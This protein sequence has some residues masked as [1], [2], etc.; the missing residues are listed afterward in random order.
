MVAY[1]EPWMERVDAMKRLQG[2]NETSVM[3]F[4]KLATYGEQLLLTIRFGNW[5]TVDDAAN[6][7]VWA[8]FWRSRDCVNPW[9]QLLSLSVNSRIMRRSI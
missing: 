5:S 4:H 8:R 9:S 6:A 2:W 7:A 3:H 1:P